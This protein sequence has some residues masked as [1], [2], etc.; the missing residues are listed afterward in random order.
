MAYDRK[1]REGHGYCAVVLGGQAAHEL[2]RRSDLAP[3]IEH[4]PRVPARQIVHRVSMPSRASAARIADALACATPLSCV[5]REAKER[6]TNRLA[7]G[8]VFRD[9]ESGDVLELDRGLYV[10]SPELLYVQLARGA[11]AAML[12]MLASEFIGSYGIDHEMLKKGHTSEEALFERTPLTSSDRLM[13]CVERASAGKRSLAQRV[14]MLMLPGARSPKEAQLAAL[15][16]L[17]RRWGGRG[18][19]GVEL[20]HTFLLSSQARRIAG[21]G[22][23]EGDLY[24]PSID[25]DVEYDSDL[26]HASDE[27]REL[28][29]RKV[30]ALRSMGV[31]VHTVTRS[32]LYNWPVFNA[33]ADSLAARAIRGFRPASSAIKLRQYELWHALLFRDEEHGR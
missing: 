23:L 22:E 11:D 25:E 30:N 9:L 8:Q 16:S 21:R 12:W 6:R 4:S 17:P 33:L 31:G 32:Q 15:F 20:N 28:D 26:F 5:V 29:I 2:Y 19:R 24:I 3:L 27:R 18:I 13:A 1:N 14:A 10:L 7:Y